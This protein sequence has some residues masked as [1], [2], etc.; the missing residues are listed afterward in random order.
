[1][2][3]P[4]GAITDL[5]NKYGDIL[6]GESYVC[7]PVTQKCLIGVIMDLSRLVEEEEAHMEKMAEEIL[8]EEDDLMT[9]HYAELEYGAMA[10]EIAGRAVMDWAAQEKLMD[11]ET[12][13]L[14]D[15]PGGV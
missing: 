5:I 14:Q 2:N 13:K 1:M 9:E 6:V 15:W 7:D 8:A 10:D 3:I 11:D 4:I 12:R